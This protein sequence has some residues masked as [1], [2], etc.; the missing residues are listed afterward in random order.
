[1]GLEVRLHGSLLE[2]ATLRFIPESYSGKAVQPALGTT[3][4]YGQ[5]TIA[6]TDVDLPDEQKGLIGA[7]LGV[8]KVEITHPDRS[9]P[10][11]Y[12][13]E[14]IWGKRSLKIAQTCWR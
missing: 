5:T 9:I 1:M 13:A 4:E 10:P 14:T 7:H 2:G 6:V 12:N 3:D 11:D 8:Y